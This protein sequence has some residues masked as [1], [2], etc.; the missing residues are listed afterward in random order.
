MSS[1]LPQKSRRGYRRLLSRPR[2]AD[3]SAEG[4][5]EK[6]KDAAG[7]APRPSSHPLLKLLRASNKEKAVAQPEFLRYLEYTREAGT[8]D[9]SS[10]RPVLYFK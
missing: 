9:P 7:V 8:W 5:G 10:D 3:A 2:S 6:K 1:L 4:V